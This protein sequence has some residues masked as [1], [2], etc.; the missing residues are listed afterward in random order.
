VSQGRIRSDGTDTTVRQFSVGT[1]VAKTHHQHYD[2]LQ[3]RIGD[4]P[5]G[6]PADTP[7]AVSVARPVEGAVYGDGDVVTADFTCTAGDHTL[8]S[9]TGTVADNATIDTSTPGPKTFTV[10]A[11]DAAGYRTVRTRQYRVVDDD[12]PAVQLIAPADG[13][14]LARGA[15][16]PAA[17]TCDD[18]GGGL[19]VDGCVGTVAAGRPVDTTRVGLH[20]FTVTATDTAGNETTVGGR[21]RVVA[22]RPD[23][24]LRPSSRSS[25]DG[26]GVYNATGADQTELARV[27]PGGVAFLVRVQNDGRAT[28]SF[29]LRS[30]APRAGWDV[31]Y[32][33]GAQQ[34]TGAVRT[35]RQW[36]R[37][38]APGG[39]RVVRVVVTPRRGVPSGSLLDTRLSVLGAGGTQDLVRMVVGRR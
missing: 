18:D 19:A 9:C 13:S 29:R 15:V 7:P 8:A 26:D 32:Q 16:V 6:W 31:R 35:G 30:S 17:F 33:L 28:D 20:D 4:G 3:Y 34:V 11:V 37:G 36:I 1:T 22:N 12:D 25:F 10:T 14:V 38:V 24:L 27:G 2:D 21:Y 5:L 39:V 23:A